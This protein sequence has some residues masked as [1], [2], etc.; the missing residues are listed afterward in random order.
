MA[1]GRRARLAAL[2]LKHR[3]PM[4]SGATQYPEAG[5]LASYWP[6]RA[7]GIPPAVLARADKT[8]E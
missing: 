6:A 1:F 8:I 5:A 4:M 7:L 3:L 2:A